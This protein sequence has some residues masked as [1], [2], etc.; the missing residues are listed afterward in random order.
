[1]VTKTQSPYGV[2][3][4][5]ERRKADRE[6]MAREVEGLAARYGWQAFRCEYTKAGDTRVNLVGPRG[7]AVG[8]EFERGSWQTDN[9]CLAWHFD[10]KEAIRNPDAPQALL[11]EVFSIY[12]GSPFGASHHRRKCTAFARGIDTLL[13]KLEVAMQMAAGGSPF[14]NAFVE[15]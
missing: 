15:G 11:S 7:L 5:T 13:D 8:V 1:M 4:L 12:Q 3:R 2:Y 6:K 14:G 10:Y 9:Y